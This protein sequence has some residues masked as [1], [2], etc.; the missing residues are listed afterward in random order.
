MKKRTL[1]AIVSGILG[2]VVLVF[3]C[4]YLMANSSKTVSVSDSARSA[5]SG[6]ED[7]SNHVLAYEKAVL[8]PPS[9]FHMID[10]RNGWLMNKNGIHHT[11]D[12]GKT[13]NNVAQSFWG[14]VL[15]KP[16]LSF[17]DAEHAYVAFKA[18]SQNNLTTP[19]DILFYATADGGNSWTE[20][21]VVGL[22]ESTESLS[23]S[24]LSFTDISNGKL[25]ILSGGA[26]GS[27][28]LMLMQTVDGGKTWDVANPAVQLPDGA[29]TF[30]F[31]DTQQ[32]YLFTNGSA[33]GNTLQISADE[34]KTWG[35]PFVFPFHYTGFLPV[36]SPAF[37]TSSQRMALFS[38]QDGKEPFRAASGQSDSDK[39][40]QSAINALYSLNTNG[41]IDK[42]LANLTT[43][44]P[45]LAPLISFPKAD[46]GIVLAS[47]NGTFGLYQ[48]TTSTKK[49]TRIAQESWMKQVVHVQFLD[50]STGYLMTPDTVYK[51]SDAGK[52][53]T[54]YKI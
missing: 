38:C 12:S 45:V 43:D 15:G 37:L 22:K 32:G 24:A 8:E 34:G 11:A 31:I 27:V 26:A 51:T 48:Y 23:L 29:F 54:S 9:D 17:V 3:V 6:S 4:V 10:A 18:R 16:Q 19:S 46:A 28:Q 35:N 2:V 36:L 1:L 20:T 33:Y 30:R 13:W 39:G 42:D 44:V 41:S 50:S 53:W 52:H 14:Q 25:Y 49:F 40:T 21:H 7:F 47:K 5:V